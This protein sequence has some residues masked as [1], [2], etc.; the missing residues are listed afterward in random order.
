VLL[1]ASTHI[2]IIA[3]ERVLILNRGQREGY[4]GTFLSYLL[5]CIGNESINELN[6]AKSLHYNNR[7]F[8][9]L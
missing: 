7:D 8:P 3:Y 2:K 5:T 9:P 6:T 4:I 1:N